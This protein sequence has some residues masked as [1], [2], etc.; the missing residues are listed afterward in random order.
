M[1]TVTRCQ[2]LQEAEFLQMILNS[3]GIDSF[4]PDDCSVSF[5]PFNVPKKGVRLQVD[6]SV[7]DEA[8]SVIEEARESMDNE[9]GDDTAS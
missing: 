3:R 2:S 7:N 4:I 5:P 8:K 6:E 9:E 1:I